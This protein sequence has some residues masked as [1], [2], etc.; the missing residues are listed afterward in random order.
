[1]A[2]EVVVKEVV[3]EKPADAVE[4]VKAASELTL[5]E[6]LASDTALAEKAEADKAAKAEADAKAAAEAKAKEPDAKAKEEADK[7]AADEAEAKAKAEEEAKTVPEY[8]TYND[9]EADSIVSVLKEAG[10]T[11]KESH[12][13][14]SKAIESGKL[15]TIDAKTLEDKLGKDK[16]TLVLMGVKSYYTKMQ[17]TVNEVVNTVHKEFGGKDNFE[18]VKTWALKVEA[19]D[20]E[21]KKAMDDYR[22]MFASNPRAAALASKELLNAYKA[23]P[24]NKSLV[25]KMVEG[26]SSASI[27]TDETIS[28]SDY[29]TQLEAAQR[30]GNRAEVARLNAVRQ[31]TILREKKA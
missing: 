19:A 4:P 21:F 2:E 8:V 31:S 14:F 9:P 16:A 27:S 6:K 25:I 18:I 1:M 7:K 26:D 20:P 15:D 13:I 24:R 12:D 3:V 22:G 30:K 17:G 28:R 11:A 29:I 10:I 5:E 23:D